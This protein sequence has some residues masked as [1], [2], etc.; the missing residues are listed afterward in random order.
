[1]KTP[2]IRI[3]SACAAIVVLCTVL[4]SCT[5]LERV[6]PTDSTTPST[7][8]QKVTD[9]EP[10]VGVIPPKNSTS[11]DAN[12]FLIKDGTL[13]LTL[14]S[15][16]KRDLGSCAETIQMSY[17]KYSALSKIKIDN[18]VLNV[19][20]KND[21]SSIGSDPD[22]RLYVKSINALGL[23]KVFDNPE[24]IVGNLNWN[25]YIADDAVIVE[26]S[27]YGAGIKIIFSSAGIEEINDD[28]SV[29]GDTEN[30]YNHPI[31]SFYHRYEGKIGYT[32]M[33]RK[34]VA[35]QDISSFFNYCVS[36]DEIYQIKGYISFEN[37][38]TEYH[39]EERI[40]VSE[41]SD[42]DSAFQHYMEQD[43]KYFKDINVETL[44]DFLQYNSERYEEFE[45]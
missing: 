32:V 5:N 18:V 27:T 39:P 8:D 25:I 30:C 21:G 36:R 26:R 24:S 4:A 14:E 28:L 40:T 1:M 34:Y 16:W 6:K 31:I 9:K 45:Y 43:S 37:G 41:N 42:L 13:Y 15:L 7:K 35:T 33:P 11:T 10:V 19:V 38:K 2:K 20:L 22:M 44:D 12:G 29:L 23:E 17:E 3:M